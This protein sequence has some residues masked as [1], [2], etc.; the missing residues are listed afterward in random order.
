MGDTNGT[1]EDID[2]TSSLVSSGAESFPDGVLELGHVYRALGA[3]R[4]RYICYLLL[5]RAQWSLSAVATKIAAWE[6]DVPEHAVS[7]Q[8]RE[9]VSL[10]LY[11]IDVPKLV[12]EAVITFDEQTETIAPGDNAEQVLA[13]LDGMATNL[14]VA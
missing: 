5:E 1:G 13:A 7:E 12:D 9:D 6:S 4:R 11:H 14:D 3:P 10:M 2:S 8:K